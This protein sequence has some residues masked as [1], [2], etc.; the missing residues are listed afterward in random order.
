[1]RVDDR[2][3]VRGGGAAFGA[4]GKR[5]RGMTVREMIEKLAAMRVVVIS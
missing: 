1:V 5:R 2:A 4:E 3:A